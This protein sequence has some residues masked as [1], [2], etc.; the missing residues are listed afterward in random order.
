M[1]QR[2]SSPQVLLFRKQDKLCSVCTAR[3]ILW[4]ML[5]AL[6]MPM[7]NWAC[8]LEYA[9]NA[10]QNPDYAEQNKFECQNET[11]ML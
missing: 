8:L 6:S 9:Q 4:V 1:L 11:M 10:P 7:S 5:Q 2:K 3:L